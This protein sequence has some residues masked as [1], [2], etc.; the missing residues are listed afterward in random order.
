MEYLSFLDD[1]AWLDWLAW[2]S[3]LPMKL[4]SMILTAKQIATIISHHEATMRMFGYS[5]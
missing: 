3:L 5:V 1:Q 2:K 4:R